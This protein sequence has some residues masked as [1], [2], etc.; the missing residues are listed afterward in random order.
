MNK[1][2]SLI[3]TNLRDELNLQINNT[4]DKA[5]QEIKT[6]DNPPLK[7]GDPIWVYDTQKKKWRFRLFKEWHGTNAI[8]FIRTNTGEHISDKCYPWPNWRIDQPAEKSN[9]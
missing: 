7:L 6:T 4:I 8:C 1:F 9:D 3:L 2:K 5:L